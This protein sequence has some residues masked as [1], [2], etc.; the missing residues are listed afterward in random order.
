MAKFNFLNLTESVRQKMQSEINSD[1][2]SKNLYM[3]NRLNDNGK[4]EYPNLLLDAAQ[5]NDEVELEKNLGGYFNATEEINGKVKKVPSNAATLL[6][7][8]EFN[9]FYIRAVCLQSIEDKIENV[10]IYRARESSWAR[11]ESEILIGNNINAEKLLKDLR[12]TIGKS[13]NLLPD[14]N[15][16]LSV[17]LTGE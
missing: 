4:L 7:Q 9:R 2:E 13:P 8:S 11:P 15:S 1:I 10:K 16:G 12:E 3:S 5:N 6:A 14:I 17:K